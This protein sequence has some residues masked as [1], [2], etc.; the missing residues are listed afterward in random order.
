[1]N[2][3]E[4]V[5][6]SNGKLNHLNLNLNQNMPKFA[7]ATFAVI[8]ATSEI[9]FSRSVA[10]STTRHVFTSLHATPQTT[11]MLDLQ[12]ESIALA[13]KK[14]TIKRYRRPR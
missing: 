9:C 14:C 5:I 6:F 10:A 8:L 11:Y 13:M 2:I 12:R 4:V 7:I 3:A 1:M